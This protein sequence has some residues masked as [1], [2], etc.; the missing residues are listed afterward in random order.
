MEDFIGGLSQGCGECWKDAPDMQGV[1]THPMVL[2][3]TK[4]WILN[5]EVINGRKCQLHEDLWFGTQVTIRRFRG[6]RKLTDAFG[7]QIKNST[8]RKK[9]KEERKQG[10]KGWSEGEKKEGREGGYFLAL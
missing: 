4:G 6:T 8:K 3:I 5:A 10:K 2:S 7:L 1:W 9:R